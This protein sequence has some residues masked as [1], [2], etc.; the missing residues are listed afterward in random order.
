MIKP[1]LVALGVVKRICRYDSSTGLG[2]AHVFIR[3]I[4]VVQQTVYNN[5]GEYIG[6]PWYFFF[7]LRIT[8]CSRLDRVG[9][10]R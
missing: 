2:N 6:I 8:V 10:G 7:F 3:S 1:Y 4:D 5:L 9:S